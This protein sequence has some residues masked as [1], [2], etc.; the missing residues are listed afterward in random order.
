M[1]DTVNRSRQSLFRRELLY[2][3]MPQ[4]ERDLTISDL[5]ANRRRVR[6]AGYEF[7]ARHYKKRFVASLVGGCGVLY[8]GL[9]CCKGGGRWE[10]CWAGT[11]LRERDGGNVWGNGRA[12]VCG[13]KEREVG[14][15]CKV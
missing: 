5:F 1:I 12:E 15:E 8:A 7:N 2:V 14:K 3:V 13:I 6:R 11:R 4:G 10:R 9:E